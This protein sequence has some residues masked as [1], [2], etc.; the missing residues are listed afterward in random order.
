MEPLML[1]TTLAYYN[2][3]YT[4]DDRPSLNF[5]RMLSDA[6]G[7]LIEVKS[8]DGTLRQSAGVTSLANSPGLAENAA[9]PA[10]FAIDDVI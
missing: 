6:S 8:H 9:K 1:A 3:R 4:P 7:Q 5:S 2:D 10:N